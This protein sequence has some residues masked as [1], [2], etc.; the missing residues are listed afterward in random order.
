MADVEK[1]LL[2]VLDRDGSIDDSESFASTFGYDHK[3]VVSSIKSLQSYEMIVAEVSGFC[4]HSCVHP[5]VLAGT[6]DSSRSPR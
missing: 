6:S 2:Q 1:H 5:S 3:A 4:I